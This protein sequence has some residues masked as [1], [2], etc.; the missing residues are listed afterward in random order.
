MGGSEVHGFRPSPGARG[1]SP[2]KQSIPRLS[3]GR[4]AELRGPDS[5]TPTVGLQELRKVLCLQTLVDTTALCPVVSGAAQ[6]VSTEIRKPDS[7]T[8]D[9]SG[10]AVVPSVSFFVK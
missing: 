4:R 3:G 9:S 5:A 7:G 2:R 10:T 1:Q 8:G 6:K